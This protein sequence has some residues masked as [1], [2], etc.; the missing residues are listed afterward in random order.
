MLLAHLRMLHTNL[1]TG[2][3]PHG[4]H[5]DMGPFGP[6]FTELARDATLGVHPTPW[7]M[8]DS[9]H[10]VNVKSLFG[11]A[12]FWTH[13]QEHYPNLFDRFADYI[14]SL[15][16][17]MEVKGTYGWS[18]INPVATIKIAFPDAFAVIHGARPSFDS[19]ETNPI[20][21]HEPSL[22]MLRIRP[23]TER[24]IRALMMPATHRTDSS[25]DFSVS[26]LT[27]DRCVRASLQIAAIQC[28]FRFGH[29]SEQCHR[30]VA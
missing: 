26:G 8:R 16:D 4:P 2:R 10:V 21:P 28:L 15:P 30:Q 6:V 14:E 27:L 23:L 22:E 17:E 25:F 3:L 11:D 1:H 12:D 9:G 13:M 7:N 19:D 24:E 29:V 18:T 5:S 20:R